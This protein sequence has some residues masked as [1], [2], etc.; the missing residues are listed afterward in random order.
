MT[1]KTTYFNRYRNEKKKRE[2]YRNEIV[3]IEIKRRRTQLRVSN[4]TFVI[5]HKFLIKI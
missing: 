1:V 3:V 2:W 4:F 5:D